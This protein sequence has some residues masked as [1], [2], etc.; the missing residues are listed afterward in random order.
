MSEH[1]V[2]S[3]RITCVIGS[4]GAGGA[5]R[6]L[7][8]MANWWVA[9]GHHVT[10]L[11]LQETTSFFPLDSRVHVTSVA[12]VPAHSRSGFVAAVRRVFRLRSTVLECRSDVVL[13][14]IDIANVHAILATV[15]CGIPVIVSER[16]DPNHH[17]LGLVWSVLR[18]MTYPMATRVV[19]QSE[20]VSRA[21]A[22]IA[23]R[24]TV[25]PNPI[26]AVSPP[27]DGAPS[28]DVDVVAIGRLS[29]EK[30]F[31]LLL[32]AIAKASRSTVLVT[33]RIW[34]DG[35]EIQSLQQQARR[36][37]I[38]SQ[39]SFPGRTTAPIAE[40][41]RGRVVVLPSRYEGFP[42][43]LGEAM[44]AGCPCIAFDSSSGPRLLIDH[45][46]DGVLVP[47]EDPDALAT[48]I[49]DAI[50]DPEGCAR[51]AGNAVNVARRY[52]VRSVMAQWDAVLRSVQA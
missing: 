38:A 44:A 6:V 37:G 21:F 8:V 24:V 25:I 15:G 31:D 45:R 22:Y 2:A 36:L 40:L 32:E 51:M 9:E 7:T 4:L 1:D 16:T 5:E 3:R 27:E 17:R 18:R 26:A 29:R 33:A 10:I 47:P 39:V 13:S 49:S 52:S 50:A 41:R 14:F 46:V 11:T 30:G 23:N 43:V 42:N 12:T 48:A 28:V 34:G 35:P 19:V 20:E